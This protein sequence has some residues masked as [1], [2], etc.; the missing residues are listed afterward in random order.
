M[1][2]HER[3]SKL[4]TGFEALEIPQEVVAKFQD[5]L[6]DDRKGPSAGTDTATP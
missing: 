5:R 2:K 1:S 6:K 3:V 4:P